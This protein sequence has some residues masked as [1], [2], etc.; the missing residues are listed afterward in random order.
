ME[1]TY[2]DEMV[3]Y[4][5]HIHRRPEEG[6]TEFET[7][8]FVVQKLQALGLPVTVGIA[9]INPDE[10]LGRDPNLVER[11]MKRALAHGVPQSFL[12]E[13][14]GYTGAVAVL[15][16]GRP[17]PTTAFRSDIDC[18]LVQETSL[19]EHLPNQLGF[20]SER[21]G[22]MHACGHDGHTAVGL[23]LAHWLVEHQDE[24]S[25]RFKL[26][27]QPAE[28]GVRGARAMVAAGVV[29]DVDYFLSGHVGGIA[30][31][32]EVAVMDGGFLA[33]TKFDITI[34]GTPAHAGNAP[35]LGHSALTA[36]CAATMML[37][38][39]PRHGEGTTRVS[40]G[41]LHAGEGRNVIAAQAKL[42]LEVRGNTEEVNAFMRD[43]VYDIFAGVDKAYR[44]K[45]HIAIAGESTTLLPSPALYD[46]VERVMHTIPGATVLPRVHVPSGSEDC[47]LFVRRVIQRGGQAAYI[48]Y[49][50]NHAGHHRPNFDLQDE[51][52]LPMAFEVYKRFALA[53]NGIKPTSAS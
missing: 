34:E 10:V 22:L 21:D 4:R 43:Y 23:T 5:R 15:D 33:S 14:G 19:A 29:D 39:I 7:T 38:G 20:A 18:V 24:L 50:C 53:V 32:G 17:G 48:L 6:W 41:T 8:Y 13:C 44:V 2:L 26:I 3:A 37:Q 27:F 36:A 25:G 47:A 46:V 40:V 35:H 11:A 1:K 45:S 52:S 51:V 9:N 31:L 30:K 42:Q 16:T 12:D 49:G 28:E